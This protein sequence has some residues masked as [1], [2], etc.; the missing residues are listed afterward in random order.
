MRTDNEVIIFQKKRT[1]PNTLPELLHSKGFRNRSISDLKELKQSYDDAAN[2][3]L[4]VDGG[5]DIND[6]SAIVE[7]L[8]KQEDLQ[9]LPIVIAARSAE[10]FER[11]LG[12]H[13][14]IAIGVRVPCTTTDIIAAISYIDEH[15]REV[16]C[17]LPE[18]PP[19]PVELEGWRGGETFAPSGGIGPVET[20]RPSPEEPAGETPSVEQA[21]RH[22]VEVF[23]HLE[24]L[25][26]MKRPL[27][28][29]IFATAMDES[30]FED[31]SCFTIVHEKA[32]AITDQIAECTS[33]WDR[34]H[35]HRS[36]FL[37][38]EIARSLDRP[39]S[40]VETTKESCLLFFGAL[41]DLPQEYFRKDYFHP[42]HQDFRQN[43]EG[44]VKEIAFRV[45]VE[46]ELPVPGKIIGKLAAFM[47]GAPAQG[48]D[49]VSLAAAIIQ[50]T[51]LVG[52]ACAKRGYFEPELAY[53]FLRRIRRGVYSRLHP[54]VLSCLVKV[55]AEAVVA[56]ALG[57][58]MP[59]KRRNDPKLKQAAQDYADQKVGPDEIKVAIQAL[60]PGM[61]LSRPIQAYDGKEI[62]SKGLVLDQDLIWRIWQLSAIRPLNAP[63]VVSPN[64]EEEEP[65]QER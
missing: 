46:L 45:G 7:L 29:Q 38:F 1:L 11:T 18:A 27:G 56:T 5:P 47:G 50:G 43:L 49:E 55:L 34:G 24:D 57:L 17:T 35:I 61:R 37:A 20:E 36:T 10:T 23:T 65:E 8:L 33:Q 54:L 64:T 63:L 52:R 48:D 6:T 41:L 3:I 26:L 14:C 2:P 28:G 9:H 42:R 19:Q 59:K 22:F 30:A 4:L 51:D 25:G 13:F 12:R 32:R 62:L 16:T 60:S 58:A 21:D 15:Y 31:K 44:K 39:E 53:D 40:F